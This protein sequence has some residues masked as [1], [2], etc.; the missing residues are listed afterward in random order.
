MSDLHDARLEEG[1]TDTENV[2]N[3]FRVQRQAFASFLIVPNPDPASAAAG[4]NVCRSH[5]V[6]VQM[7]L[8]Q[9][10]CFRNLLQVIPVLDDPIFSFSKIGWTLPI[11]PTCQSALLSESHQSKCGGQ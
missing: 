6:E 9:M 8:S 3:D 10:D 7:Y 4:T 2:G 1:G 11:P 5:V